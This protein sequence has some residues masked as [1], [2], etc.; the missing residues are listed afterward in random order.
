LSAFCAA[1]PQQSTGSTLKITL[2]SQARRRSS[3]QPPEASSL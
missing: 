1:P 3:D 2:E